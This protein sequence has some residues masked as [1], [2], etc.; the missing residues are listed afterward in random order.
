MSQSG[1]TDKN[2]LLLK[3]VFTLLLWNMEV[4]NIVYLWFGGKETKDRQLLWIP[5]PKIDPS[6]S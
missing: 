6:L 4:Y 2:D 5:L 1:E 3:E